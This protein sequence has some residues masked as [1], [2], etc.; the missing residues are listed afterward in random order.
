MRWLDRSLIRLCARFAQ[1]EKD[2]QETFRLA[3]E[4]SMYPQYMFHLR[5]S[6]FLQVNGI[7][8]HRCSMVTRLVVISFDRPWYITSIQKAQ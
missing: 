1:F 7:E 8:A 2:K 4:F 3:P 5:R 6:Q